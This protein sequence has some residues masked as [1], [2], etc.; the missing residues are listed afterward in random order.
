MGKLRYSLD[1]VKTNL[2]K[3]KNSPPPQITQNS[4][5]F[6]RLRYILA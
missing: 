2:K 6:N 3:K 4:I 5:N 1:I